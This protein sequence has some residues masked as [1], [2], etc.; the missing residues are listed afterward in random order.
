[1]NDNEKQLW[2]SIVHKCSSDEKQFLYGIMN[3]MQR[4]AMKQD[5]YYLYLFADDVKTVIENE[6]IDSIEKDMKEREYI[7]NPEKFFK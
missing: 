1:M 4:K 6:A 3:Y 2:K 5:L 7:D